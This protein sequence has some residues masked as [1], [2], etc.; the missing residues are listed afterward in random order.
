VSFRTLREHG[1][2][3]KQ[4]ELRH[5]QGVSVGSADFGNC[6]AVYGRRLEIPSAHHWAHTHGSAK[7]HGGAPV[8]QVGTPSAVIS[9]RGTRFL[10]EV[11]GH[12]VTEVDVEEGVVEIDSVSGIG[13]PVLTDPGFSSRGGENSAPESARP[14][15]E[16]RPVLERGPIARISNAPT[17]GTKQPKLRLKMPMNT[18]NCGISMHRAKETPAPKQLSRP[19]PPTPQNGPGLLVYL[20]TS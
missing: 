5:Y 10:V 7:A 11:N 1:K 4:L 2:R 3:L 12:H 18:A 20:T 15:P 14:T 17:T 9:V 6:P 8:F 16:L 19:I 13:A